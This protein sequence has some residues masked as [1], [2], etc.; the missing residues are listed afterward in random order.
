MTEDDF[1]LICINEL[2]KYII[3]KKVMFR[4]HASKLM[5]GSYRITY[6]QWFEK[7]GHYYWENEFSS[8]IDVIDDNKNKCIKM[9]S[10]LLNCF[11]YIHYDRNLNL[12]FDVCKKDVKTKSKEFL[13]KLKYYQNVYSLIRYEKEIVD[14]RVDVKDN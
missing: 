8:F 1:K 11:S 3:I 14:E 12:K 2:P 9:V 10:D 4:M 13:K 6:G 5:C 7:A